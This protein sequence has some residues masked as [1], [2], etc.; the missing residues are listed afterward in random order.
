MAVLGV[1]NHAPEWGGAD[2]FP[3]A[4]AGFE[5]APDPELYAE[6]AARVVAR[7]GSKVAAYEIWNEP[8]AVTGWAPTISAAAY[9]E[10]LKAPYTAIKNVNGADP[11]DPRSS[12]AF[13]AR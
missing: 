6:Y 13:S 10:V 12:R 7:Y 11:N 8:N 2:P 1:L 9:T 3:W 5:E 4:S